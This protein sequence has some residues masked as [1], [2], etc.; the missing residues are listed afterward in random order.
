[1]AKRSTMTRL[2]GKEGAHVSVEVLLDWVRAHPLSNGRIIPVILWGA[3]GIGKTSMVRAYCKQRG[4]KLLTYHPAHD[5]DGSAIVG[6]PYYDPESGLT[7][8][9]LPKWLPT[10]GEKPGILFID[11]LNRANKDVLAGLMEVLGEGTISQSGWR[12]PDGW[13][14]VCAANPGE[15]GYQVQELDEAMINRMVHYAPGWDAPEWVRWAEG[16]G[17]AQEIVDFA[18]RYRTEYVDIGEE[19]LPQEVVQKGRC[20]P[21]S[22][23][24]LAALYEPGMDEHLLRVL[25]VGLIGRDATDA[26]LAMLKEGEI[27]PLR[28][29][30]VLAQPDTDEETGEHRYPYEGTLKLWEALP[31]GDQRKL[32]LASVERVIARLLHEE[33]KVLPGEK[34]PRAKGN[35][36]AQALGRF[37]ALQQSGIKEEAFECLARSAPSW[38]RVVREAEQVWSRHLARSGQLTPAGAVRQRPGVSGWTGARGALPHPPPGE[39]PAGFGAGPALPAG[40]DHTGAQAPDPR[41]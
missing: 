10:S 36:P 41:Y 33:P 11:E 2:L 22:L 25:A 18:L 37:L 30:D 28:A 38:Y 14:I 27:R 35:F 8:Y 9:A 19:Q 23:E 21:R 5:K 12:L 7:S 40:S 6:E 3:A 34:E 13:A 26:L 17:I 15:V 1:M 32:I 20:S 4:L 24:Y 39:L 31:V 16:V 29:E